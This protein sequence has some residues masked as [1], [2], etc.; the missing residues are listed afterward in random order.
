VI[1]LLINRLSRVTAAYVHVRLIP[2]NIASL[3]FEG[4]P[5]ASWSGERL[6]CIRMVVEQTF[7]SPHN[8]QQSKN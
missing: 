4:F 7:G 1:G 5:T 8:I 2:K 3:A 6:L